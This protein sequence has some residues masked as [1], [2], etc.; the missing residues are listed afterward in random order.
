MVK[1]PVIVVI[2]DSEITRRIERNIINGKVH[3]AIVY[4]FSS[5]SDLIE[6][7]QQIKPNI[8]ILDNMFPVTE[9]HAETGK[10]ILTQIREID[11]DVKIVI[12]SSQCSTSIINEL[13][14]L[15]ADEYIVKPATAENLGKIICKYLDTDNTLRDVESFN[16]E[17]Q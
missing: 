9:T 5:G 3:D 12:Y 8:I 14:N 17:K 11:N 2:D 16:K 15:G 4:T 1:F 10:D 13:I 6:N 7:Y